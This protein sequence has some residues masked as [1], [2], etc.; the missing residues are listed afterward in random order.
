MQH[1]EI[2]GFQATT[3]FILVGGAGAKVRPIRVGVGNRGP[4]AKQSFGFGHMAFTRD[5]ML[6]R[7]IDGDG[8]VLHAFARDRA[9]KV[10]VLNSSESD[11]A[12]PRTPKSINRPDAEDSPTTKSSD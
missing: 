8:A 9:G 1:L 3:S 6:V 7:L 5:T 10:R 11:I 12:M 2:D 4:F